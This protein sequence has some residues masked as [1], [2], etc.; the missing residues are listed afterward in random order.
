MS[1]VAPDIVQEK[2][3]NAE[4]FFLKTK[5]G[6]VCIHPLFVTQALRTSY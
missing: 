2:D 4:A 6:Q 5:D 3:I 1:L